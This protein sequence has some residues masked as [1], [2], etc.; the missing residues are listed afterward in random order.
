[1]THDEN[2]KKLPTGAVI[3]LDLVCAPY[4]SGYD[5]PP[6]NRSEKKAVLE[7]LKSDE[8]RLFSFR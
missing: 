1:M 7:F 3:K 6:M 8:A 2:Y 4:V 5:T